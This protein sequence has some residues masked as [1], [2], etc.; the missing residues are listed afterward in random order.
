MDGFPSQRASI[1][2]SI[3]C[4]NIIYTSCFPVAESPCH[5]AARV[6]VDY[7]WLLGVLACCHFYPLYMEHQR[8]INV[9]LLL[10]EHYYWA[11]YFSGFYP[12]A[13]YLKS[14]KNMTSLMMQL[15]YFYGICPI[16]CNFGSVYSHVVYLLYPCTTKLLGGILVSLCP[17]VRP[18]VRPASR[19][20]SMAP[21]VEFL[22]IFLN[23]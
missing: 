2:E 7:R 22:A 11:W 21:T 1:A 6:A 10:R 18:S 5:Q 15:S 20:R 23:L 19:V 12:Q 14:G 16:S 3:P 4:N 8:L 9:C 17:S 13:K